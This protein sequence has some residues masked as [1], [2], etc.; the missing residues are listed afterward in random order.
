MTEAQLQILQALRALGHIFESG[1]LDYPAYFL[2]TQFAHREQVL[3]EALHMT[4]LGL[5]LE[6][7]DK[8]RYRSCSD[9]IAAVILSKGEKDGKE[10]ELRTLAAEMRLLSFLDAFSPG[11]E[12]KFFV[13]IQKDQRMPNLYNLVSKRSQGGEAI[14]DACLV[15]ANILKWAG[16]FAPNG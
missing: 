3:H 16:V 4:T 14:R 2:Y 12:R 15:T 1:P 10:N 9:W 11:G 13:Q 7:W 5:L 6:D 8:R